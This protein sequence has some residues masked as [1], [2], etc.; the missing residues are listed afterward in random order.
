MYLEFEQSGFSINPEK[1]AVKGCYIATVYKDAWFGEH[2][3][4]QQCP[5]LKVDG[6]MKAAIIQVNDIKSAIALC[7]KCVYNINTK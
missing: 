3:L 5:I 2:A 4:K 7:Q 6:K 1:V